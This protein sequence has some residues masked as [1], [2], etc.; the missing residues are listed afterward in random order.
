MG[1]WWVGYAL[2]GCRTARR[3]TYRLAA[4]GTPSVGSHLSVFL[5]GLMGFV[6]S[7]PGRSF[8]AAS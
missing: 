7:D 5:V 3:Q 2:A 6:S 4:M 8:W 1:L